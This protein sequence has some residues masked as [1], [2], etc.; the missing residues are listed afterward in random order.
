MPIPQIYFCNVLEAM[1]YDVAQ[2]F[3]VDPKFI[4]SVPTL[5]MLSITK[6]RPDRNCYQFEASSNNDGTEI[7][8]ISMSPTGSPSG[9]LE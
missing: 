6:L 1:C 5:Q 7:P 4:L 8:T 9:T 3:A 2:Y